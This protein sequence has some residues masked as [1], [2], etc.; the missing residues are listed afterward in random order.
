MCNK[1][2]IKRGTLIQQAMLQEAVMQA[3]WAALN[4]FGTNFEEYKTTMEGQAEA[5]AAAAA[6][7]ASKKGGKGAGAVP[8]I[9]AEAILPVVLALCSQPGAQHVQLL[10]LNAVETL[11][12]LILEPE[13]G[14][15]LIPEPPMEDVPEAVQE[16]GASPPPP[17]PAPDPTVEPGPPPSSDCFLCSSMMGWDNISFLVESPLLGVTALS[18][19]P[20]DCRPNKASG[21]NCLVKPGFY[22]QQLLGSC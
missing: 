5:V 22:N 15:L 14:K 1:F 8:A 20:S 21:H 7:A 19:C 3:N 10:E 4:E 17:A 11:V 9:D 16:D 18:V 2:V 13:T 12:Q 6:E